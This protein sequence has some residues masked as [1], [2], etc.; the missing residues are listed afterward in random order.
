MR[1][2]VR[3]FAAVCG[4]I[5]GLILFFGAIWV[6]AFEGRRAKPMELGRFYKGYAADPVGGLIGLGWG[7]VD[8]VVLGG[9]FAW[10]YNQL[11]KRWRQ[12]IEI[13]I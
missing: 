11:A 2:N 9:A 8:G 13:Q 12:R 6:W 1:Y 4:I 5:W 10:L 7:L 3:V